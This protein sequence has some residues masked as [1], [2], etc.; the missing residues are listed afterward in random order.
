MQIWIRRIW[1]LLGA[2][3]LLAACANTNTEF[4]SGRST[5]PPE[6]LAAATLLVGFEQIDNLYVRSVDLG[7]VAEDGINGL[8][9][10]D[11]SIS[12]DLSDDVLSLFKSD[13]AIAAYE[14]PEPHDARGWAAVTLAAL[15]QSRVSSL[16]LAD[17]DLE[18]LLTAV[19]DGATN[20]LDEYSR[21]APPNQATVE[22]TLREGYGGVGM[23]LDLE[24]SGIVVIREIFD[25]GPAARAGM[26]AGGRII[27]IDGE[28]SEDW[29]L[30]RIGD[31]L[32][33]PL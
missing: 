22:R 25:E 9:E 10:L 13:V 5:P 12:A 23:L 33:G 1:L 32:R 8:G 26:R 11:P 20:G 28:P 19:F 29:P 14:A 27:A 2:T 15:E 18:T 31:T 21:Y 4:R 3:A 16:E 6:Q 30:E 7:T 24:P 17:A